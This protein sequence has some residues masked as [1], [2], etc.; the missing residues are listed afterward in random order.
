MSAIVVNADTLAEVED[1]T[2]N[3]DGTNDFTAS[4][5]VNLGAGDDTVDVIDTT[6][7]DPITVDLGDGDDD[8]FDGD[9]WRRRGHGE[10]RGRRRHSCS[11]VAATTR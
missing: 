2:V 7:A 4:I 1:Q 6:G 10:R 9:R 11:A 5:T 8:D 3:I